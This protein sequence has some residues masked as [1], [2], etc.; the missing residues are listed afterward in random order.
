M[1]GR[2]IGQR[3]FTDGATRPVYEDERGQYVLDDGEWIDGIWLVPIEDAADVPLVV[4]GP[5]GMHED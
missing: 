4:R 5:G 3:Q 1:S 2:L